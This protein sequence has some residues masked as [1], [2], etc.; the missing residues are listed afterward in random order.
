MNKIEKKT[1]ENGMAWNGTEWK[2]IYRNR[3]ERIGME[4]Y[5][6]GDFFICKFFFKINCSWSKVMLLGEVQ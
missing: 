1:E 4:Y 3:T 5:L 2:Q 6:I